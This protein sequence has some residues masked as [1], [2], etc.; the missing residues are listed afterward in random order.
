MACDHAALCQRMF[1]Q[2]EGGKEVGRHVTTQ[3]RD[4]SRQV[5]AVRSR[6]VRTFLSVA[7]P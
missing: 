4:T 5:P 2:Q 1:L 7:G 3:G 6:D